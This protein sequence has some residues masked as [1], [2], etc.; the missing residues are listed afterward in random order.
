MIQSSAASTISAPVSA[1]DRLLAAAKLVFAR[2]GLQGATTRA[3]AQEAGVN[4]VTLFRLFQS[5]ERLIGE[6]MESI[7]M[8]K[9]A[10]EPVSD[11]KKWAGNLKSNLRR[12][13]ETLYAV[14]ERDEPLIRTMLGEARR[15]PDHAKKIILDAVKPERERFIANLEA[16]RKAGQVRKGVNLPVAADAFTGMLLAGM[17]RHTAG[18]IEGY[19]AQEFV[20]T[21]VDLF[22]AG[23]A[24]PTL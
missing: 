1:R 17:L 9:Q 19:S 4:E 14:M 11:Q 23:L 21:C 3:I 8:Q 6:V 5:K 10:A 20:A 22:A 15:Y 2:D 13:A 7:V 12:Y 18:C 16:A 24:S